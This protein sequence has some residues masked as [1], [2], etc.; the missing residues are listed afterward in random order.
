MLMFARNVRHFKMFDRLIHHY[1]DYER[2]REIEKQIKRER[3]SKLKCSRGESWVWNPRQ[4]YCQIMCPVCERGSRELTVLHFRNHLEL[5]H[6][7][8]EVENVKVCKL[9]HRQAVQNRLDI[10][11][12]LIL[13][14]DSKAKQAHI[15]RKHPNLSMDHPSIEFMP[16]YEKHKRTMGDNWGLEGVERDTQK[17]YKYAKEN[18]SRA[19]KNESRNSGM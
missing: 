4:F 12:G 15:E 8:E 16:I 18:F 13:D 14:L 2:E 9:C 7:A 19:K 5:Q 11:D 1:S 6:T 10:F 17:I 3:L